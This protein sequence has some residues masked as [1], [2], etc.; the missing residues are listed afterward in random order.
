MA[1]LAQR[2]GQTLGRDNQSSLASPNPCELAKFKGQTVV[3]FLK[4]D[5]GVALR[6][7]AC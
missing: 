4:Y 1:G 6:K 3:S 5:V 2:C 7:A